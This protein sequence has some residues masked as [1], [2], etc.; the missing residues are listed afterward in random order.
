VTDERS[1]VLLAGLGRGPFE[2]IAPVLE[3]QRLEIERVE[4]PEKA[5]EMARKEKV[6]LIIFDAEPGEMALDDVVATL[7]EEGS[8]SAKCSLLVMA[9]PGTDARARQLVGNGVNRVMLLNDSEEL[10]EQQVAELL[11]IAPRAAVRFATRLYTSLDNG[12]EE[13]FG[14]T[15]NLSISGMLVQTPTLLEPGQRV[16]FEILIED[17]DGRV[18]GDAEVVRHASKDREGLKGVGIR[19]LGFSE[20]SRDVL[21]AV[22]ADA[23][24]ELFAD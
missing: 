12:T 5:V 22:I 6:D 11:H 23:F 7:R 16:T 3:R 18:M 1:K 8:A 10:I 14:Q 17:R 24:A 20:D 21:D 15:A 19:F 13:I 9:E 4:S 2:A